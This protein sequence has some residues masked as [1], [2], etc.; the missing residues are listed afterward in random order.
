MAR[1]K[2]V[3]QAFRQLAPAAGDRLAMTDCCLRSA[4]LSSVF[5][6]LAIPGFPVELDLQDAPVE[7]GQFE[8]Q[9]IYEEEVPELPF[10]FPGQGIEAA[11]TLNYRL[12]AD[13]N[14]ITFDTRNQYFLYEL[15]VKPKPGVAGP[16]MHFVVNGRHIGSFSAQMVD[17]PFEID[18]LNKGRIHLPV[19]SLDSLDFLLVASSWPKPEKVDVPGEKEVPLH[20][21]NQQKLPVNVIGIRPPSAKGIWSD[22]SF[23]VQGSDQFKEFEIE[24]GPKLNDMIVIRAIPKTSSAFIKV[25][26]PNIGKDSAQ[27]TITAYLDYNTPWGMKRSL[28][29]V[30]P[31][32]FVPWP[33]LLLPALALGALIGSLIPVLVDQRRRA[34]WR[35]A[36]AVSLLVAILVELIAIV[37]VIFD[38]E[39][40]LFGLRLDPSQ[41][42]S[43]IVIGGVMG[44]MGFRSL[45]VFE[46][47]I[48]KIPTRK[49]SKQD[50]KP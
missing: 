20:L 31:V 5:L 29:I 34:T 7:S 4:L 25:L 1:V 26:L 47:I 16:I 11:Q 21:R 17:V 44:L 15:Y 2:R 30:V 32:Q 23:L 36:F 35:R 14:S 50:T 13:L 41:I 33:P 19:F 10:T 24:P 43:A 6:F 40:R 45:D 12:F 22:V 18:A 37:L 42:I 39:F 49:R 48:D 38:S 46:T 28:P 8:F 9:T 3:R 27:D